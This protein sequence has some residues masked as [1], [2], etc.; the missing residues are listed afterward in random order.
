VKNIIL[1]RFNTNAIR[2]T[3]E[4]FN[5]FRRLKDRLSKLRLEIL[6]TSIK[7]SFAFEELTQIQQKQSTLFLLLMSQTNF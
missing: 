2:K 6:L 5:L 7:L 3:L 1:L 4:L